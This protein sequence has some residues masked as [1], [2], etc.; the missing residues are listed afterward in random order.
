MRISIKLIKIIIRFFKINIFLL[1][2]NISHITMNNQTIF[3][4]LIVLVIIYYLPNKMTNF[5]DAN[6]ANNINNVNNA[7]E[8]NAN[9][10][11][12]KE[13]SQSI[14][15][16]YLNKNEHKENF[17]TMG[18]D[19]NIGNDMN[20]IQEINPNPSELSKSLSKS[21]VPDFQPNYLNI[22]PDLNSYG[23]AT[24]NPQA[25]NFYKARGFMNPTDGY[26]FADSVSYDLSHPYQTRYCVKQN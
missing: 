4:I 6:N 5:N 13:D 22:N 25:D 1:C 21:L 7:N 8:V 20:F 16:K 26:N 10:I 3:I 19:M 24:T 2:Y 15:N 11:D 9:K 23:Y 18:P 12:I 14:I 17:S